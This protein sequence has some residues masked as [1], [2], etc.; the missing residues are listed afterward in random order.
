L[1]AKGQVNCHC[2]NGEAKKFGRFENKNRLV[3]RYRCTRCAKTFSESQ[4]MDGMRVDFKQACQVVNLL[5][6]SMGIRAI[7]RITGLH[8]ETI[9]NILETVGQKAASF[10]D[11]K[12]R[13]LNIEQVQTDEIHS[14][15]Y[16]KQ[17]N[18]PPRDSERGEQYTFFAVDRESKLII[19]WLVGKRTRDNGDEFFS[20]L[21]SRL[22]NR[23]Q[24]T[25]DNWKIHSGINGAVICAFG[26][27][28]DYAVETKIFA[29]PSA[30]LP[31]QLI[32]CRRKR[33]IGNPDLEMATTAHAE[34]TNLSARTFTRRFTR[35]TLGYSK[36]IDNL[37]H[38]VALFV[39][40]FNFVRKHS[41]HDKT[42]AEACGLTAG[43]M[44]VEQLLAIGCEG[45]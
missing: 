10:L 9:L 23:V 43:A 8:Q 7:Q 4:P 30:F 12:V 11:S 44:T 18:T 42:P 32:G 38:A 41:A 5:C 14:I 2:C 20:D 13:N 25:T 39:W 15:V 6:E 26:G 40:H 22:A 24:L 34:R 31:L 19:N 29:K 1:A 35:C 21:K 45:Y 16:S 33:R 17:Q 3:Q 36:K 28:V 37:R 27:D